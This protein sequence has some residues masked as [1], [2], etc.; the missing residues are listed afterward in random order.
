MAR[1][2]KTEYDAATSASNE[3][4][5]DSQKVKQVKEQFSDE[6]KYNFTTAINALHQFRDI[7][8][9]YRK[10]IATFDKEQLIG[11]LKNIGS[12]E[13][14][15]RNLSW[16]MFY[17][18]QIYRRIILYN[19]CMFELGARSIIPKY[20]LIQ[21]NNDKQILKSYYDTA[22]MLDNMNLQANFLKIFISCFTQ[23]VFYGVAYYNDDGLYIL[24]LP[25]EY[26]KL[27]G[28]FTNGDFA[29][30]F[31]MMYFSGANQD[32]LEIWGEPFISMYKEYL[33]DTINNRWMLMP[34]K[35]TACFKHNVEDW[36]VIVPPFSGLLNDIISLE[37]TKNV[38]AIA[39]EQ[40]I[41]KMIYLS[42][43]TL[44]KTIDDWKVD[45]EI[46]IQY[47]D[48]M[49]EDAVPDYTSAAIVPGKLDTISFDDNKN[50]DINKVSNATKNVLNNSG[51][52][53]LLNSQS[54]QG[55][56]GLLAAIKLDTKIAI[57][58]LLPQVQGWLNRFL[59]YYISDPSRVKFFEVS[60]FT[61]SDLRK[62]LLE[63][64]TY[65]LPTKLAVNVLSGFSELETLALNH[66]EEDILGL[67][68]IF[69]SPLQSSHTTS[70]AGEED[71]KKDNTEL[72]DDGEASREKR[73]R[74][75]G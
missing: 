58:S 12:N 54:I 19:S 67:G 68:D 15:L 46:L 65:S 8:K 25:P 37:D 30:A 75:N 33:K 28:Q 71:L 5:V 40:D 9:N 36:M 55:T 29:Y 27:V 42:M 14:N 2:K 64:A 17:R 11:Y 60:Y 74:S 32:L 21:N 57:S 61:K 34:E 18:S 73:D 53:Q 39:D 4:Y 59:G 43:E 10:S 6:Q 56:T 52:A 63:N 50:A 41:Y 7:T 35:Y 24:P 51:G 31:N 48:R 23:D 44:G 16:Y 20:S 45:P 38:Q 1:I 3:K 70:N 47:F 49:C 22:A 72:T 26:C 13:N 62:E 66:L 69:T